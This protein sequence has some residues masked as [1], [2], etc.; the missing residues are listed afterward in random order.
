MGRKFM[1][2]IVNSKVLS[3]AVANHGHL[4]MSRREIKVFAVLKLKGICL[5]LFELSSS[6]TECIIYNCDAARQEEDRLER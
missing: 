4:S 2:M 3:E 5:L 6:A 1:V